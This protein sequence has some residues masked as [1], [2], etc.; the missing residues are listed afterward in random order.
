MKRARLAEELQSPIAHAKFDSALALELVRRW[1]WGELSAVQVQQLAFKAYTDAKSLMGSL[2]KSPDHIQKSLTSLAH[3]GNSG[4]HTGNINKELKAWLGEPNIPITN[5]SITMQVTKPRASELAVREVD[6]PFMLPH[7][8]FSYLYKN[9]KPKFEKKFLGLRTIGSSFSDKLQDFWQGVVARRDPRIMNHPMCARQSWQR[10]AIPLAI[11]GDAVPVIRVGEPGNQSLDCISLNSLLSKGPTLAM[12][13]LIFSVFEDNKVPTAGDKKG[14]M[15]EVWEKNM[16]SLDALYQGCFLDKDADGKPWADG[17]SDARI[18]NTTLA[19]TIEPYFGVLWSIKGDLD[20][21]AKSLHLNH[22]AS[23]EPCPY[24]P[25]SKN[26]GRPF[27]PTNFTKTAEWKTMI[28]TVLAWLAVAGELH[29]LFTKFVFISILNVEADELHILYLGVAMYFLGSILHIL[30]FDIF[31]TVDEDEA[32]HTIWTAILDEYRLQ[33]TPV[34]FTSMS[35]SSF[36]PST[37]RKSTYPKLKGRGAEIKG[38]ALPLLA[39]WSKF[40]RDT[41]HDRKVQKALSLLCDMQHI[42]DDWK[43]DAFMSTAASETFMNTTEDSLREYSYLGD[44]AGRSGKCLFSAVPKLHWL[45]HMAYR[46]R[47]LNPRRVATFMDEDFVKY[48]KMIGE[49]CTAGTQLHNVP[50]S[51]MDKYRWGMFVESLDEPCD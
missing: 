48:M 39:V 51:L 47:W 24:C 49:R 32:F 8:V 43:E 29:P 13:M 27:W 41:V 44:Q 19:S 9:D 15:D 18:A 38:L 46:A 36:I 35:T 45:W 21:Y 28:H 16:W 23:N 3:L 30:T 10:W 17:T 40:K 50:I 33:K 20:W 31:A 22:Y 37:G 12:K 25:C 1:C 6:V 7:L 42:L 34:Q 14:T 26:K 5:F 4:N 2:G 11:H